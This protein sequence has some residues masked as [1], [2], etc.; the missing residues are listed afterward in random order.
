MTEKQQIARRHNW[1]KALLM[2]MAKVLLKIVKE[3][4]LLSKYAKDDLQIA[5][6]IIQTAIKDWR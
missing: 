1:T 6:L 4:A 2:G 5:I 3:D